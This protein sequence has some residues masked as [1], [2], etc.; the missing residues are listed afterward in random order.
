MNQSADTLDRDKLS[1]LRAGP[2]TIHLTLSLLADRAD[3]SKEFGAVWPV[4]RDDAM[5]YRDSAQMARTIEPFFDDVADRRHNPDVGEFLID[6]RSQAKPHDDDGDGNENLNETIAFEFPPDITWSTEGKSF[7][8]AIGTALRLPAKCRMFWFM[9]PNGALSFHLSF[10]ATYQHDHRHAY[11]LS[12]LQKMI[13]ETENTDASESVVVW[14]ES[15]TSCRFWDFVKMNFE[16]HALDLFVGVKLRTAAAGWDGSF[17]YWD[18]LLSA[19]KARPACKAVILLEDPYYFHLLDAGRRAVLKGF[20]GIDAN[21]KTA[22]DGQRYYELDASLLASLD[23]IDFDYYFLSGFFQNIIDFLRQ[24]T[25]EV[26]DGT[27]PIY[28]DEPGGH[29]VVFANSNIIYEIA[30]RSRSL[31]AARGYIGICPY[32]FLVHIM[33]FHNEALI[34]NFEGRI[35]I[36]VAKM[37]KA[38]LTDDAAAIREMNED[39]TETIL[40]EFYAFRLW[41]LHEVQQHMYF[42]VFRYNTERTF[43]KRILK[44]RG[45]ETRRRHWADVLAQLEKTAQDISDRVR[46]AS[47]DRLNNVLLVITCFSIFQVLFQSSDSLRKVFTKPET[48]P[49]FVRQI[50]D[51]QFQD[52]ADLLFI[53]I[54]VGLIVFALVLY[55]RRKNARRSAGSI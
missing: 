18:T 55:F 8:A 25:S 21:R 19:G 52:Y 45:L 15:G 12:L 33:S 13:I 26:Q 3:L 29:F 36:L 31:N 54:S 28:P 40:S 7:K 44:V 49:G 22:P 1:G 46:Q 17:P 5:Q 14:R 37:K 48:A 42:N 38:G 10:E 35:K 47:D 4:S 50:Q 11:A 6:T 16:A 9:H 24:D 41:I 39:R 23:G 27:D 53:P 2:G 34:G 20:V 30:A 43:F 51:G 32:L